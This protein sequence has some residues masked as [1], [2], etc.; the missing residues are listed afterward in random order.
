MSNFKYKNLDY[1]VFVVLFIGFIF[2]FFPTSNSTLDSFH[3]ANCVRDAN[4]FKPHHLLYNAFPYIF[5]N[6][7]NINDTLAFL[8]TM[9]AVFATFCLFITRSVLLHYKDI[10]ETALFVLLLGSCFGFIRFSIDGETY[11]LPLFFSLC[12]SYSALKKKSVFLISF[13]AATAC[14]F[15]QMFILWWFGLYLFIFLEY[16]DKRFN[17]FLIYFSTALIIP[18]A[19]FLVFYLTEHDA[20]NIIE[21]VLHDYIKYEGVEVS[22]KSTNL[23]FIPINLIRTFIQVH[24][25]FIPLFQQYTLLFILGAVSVV[26]FILALF[27]VKNSVS[28]KFSISSFDSN[29]AFAHLVIF[30]L[31]LLFACISDGNAEFMYMLPFL[32]TIWLAVKYNV[33]KKLTAYF[34]IGLFTWNFC[35]GIIP[36]HFIQLSPDKIFVDYIAAHPTETYFVKDRNL[37]SSLLEYY[38]PEKEIEIHSIKKIDTLTVSNKSVLTDVIWNDRFASRANII[39]GYNKSLETEYK[40]EVVDVLKYDLGE[41]KIVRMSIESPN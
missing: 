4:L 30:F 14:L 34:S 31:H 11:I 10:K 1:T 38:Y 19:Y 33:N 21:Y 25:Y 35:F 17:N 13:F 41:L 28:K 2:L 7:F 26:F 5:T 12:A 3:Y 22:F 8:C 20:N 36:F 24:G 27:K 16:R 39:T 40:L 15:H 29:Y 6:L 9:N 23:F 32:F 37:T 18:I